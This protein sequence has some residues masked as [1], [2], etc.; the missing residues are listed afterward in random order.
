MGEGAAGGGPVGG[1]ELAV[2]GGG[3]LAGVA[4]A[5]L[6][7]HCQHFG[8]AGL[9]ERLGEAAGLAGGRAAVAGGKEYQR[10]GMTR[11]AQ[12]V[13]K[14]GGAHRHGGAVFVFELD[15][16]GAAVAGEVE[17]VVLVGG[18]GVA[19]GVRVADFEDAYL[20]VAVLGGFFEGV[21]NAL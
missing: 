3:Q 10:Q 7:L 4:V 5:D 8:Y 13:G 17:H 21:E 14:I 11:G 15:L 2:E 6:C 18:E 1:V 20:G 12:G 9:D 16:A 19:D